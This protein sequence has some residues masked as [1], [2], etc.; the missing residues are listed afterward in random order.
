SAVYE[1]ATNTNDVG[2][3]KT[4]SKDFKKLC[5]LGKGGFGKVS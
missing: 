3:G 5:T 2:Y 1:E 4:S